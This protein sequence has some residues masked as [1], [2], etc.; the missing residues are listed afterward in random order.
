MKT[1]SSSSHSLDGLL[2]RFITAGNLSFPVHDVINFL[3][4]I[5]FTRWQQYKLY[6]TVSQLVTEINTAKCWVTV[7]GFPLKWRKQISG[8]FSTINTTH[9]KIRPTILPLTTFYVVL[10][11]KHGSENV[12]W[13]I[14]C[15]FFI[16]IDA[17]KL[18]CKNYS[19]TEL[20][21]QENTSQIQDFFSTS[22][23]FQD[24]SGPEKSKLKFPDFSVPVGTLGTV[25]IAIDLFSA[26]RKWISAIQVFATIKDRHLTVE[27]LLLIR[28]HHCLHYFS[29]IMQQKHNN[30]FTANKQWPHRAQF[31]SALN[32]YAKHI[33]CEERMHVTN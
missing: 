3:I 25:N 19:I 29:T 14:F 11:R 20:V 4:V 7:P 8:L 18:N 2:H 1:S 17:G 23:Q 24:F 10:I 16:I 5:H 30:I 32:A 21:F 33:S 13:N 27:D 6:P 28:F 15:W 31:P 12:T 9:Q 22:V 26:D